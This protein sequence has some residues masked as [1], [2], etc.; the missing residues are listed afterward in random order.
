MRERKWHPA[1]THYH[2]ATYYHFPFQN[3]QLFDRPAFATNLSPIAQAHSFV[4]CLLIFR[5]SGK[6]RRLLIH[7]KEMG[8]FLL[9]LFWVCF[10]FEAGTVKVQSS[11][12]NHMLR[13]LIPFSLFLFS[14]PK[15]AEL[16]ANRRSCLTA[17]RTPTGD[18]G[19]GTGYLVIQELGAGH[20]GA[21]YKVQRGY[22]GKAC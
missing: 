20:F 18:N 16:T 6:L 9:F 22:D 10:I 21:V 8:V 11:P 7:F 2:F 12:Q 17:G 1:A 3:I 15:D 4:L 5:N 19:V 13:F 14:F